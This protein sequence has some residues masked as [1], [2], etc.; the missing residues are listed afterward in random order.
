MHDVGVGTDIDIVGVTRVVVAV[1]VV[2][3][4]GMFDA[5]IGVSVTIGVGVA[6]A[7]GVAV[8]VDINV[9]VCCS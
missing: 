1:V 4:V 2:T 5:A 9:G 3:D 8:G 6:V 7:V